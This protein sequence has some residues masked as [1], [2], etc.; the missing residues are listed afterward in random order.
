MKKMLVSTVFA[1]AILSGALSAYEGAGYV[2]EWLAVDSCLDV[3]GSFDYALLA[4]DHTTVHPYV[5]YRQRHPASLGL[6]GAGIFGVLVAG[7]VAKK[8]SN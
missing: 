3:G 5:P 6:F 2:R 7:T 4:C 1:F 8:L